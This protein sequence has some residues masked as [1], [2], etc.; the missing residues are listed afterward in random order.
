MNIRTVKLILQGLGAAILLMIAH[1]AALIS[2]YHAVLYHSILPMRSVVWGTLIDLAVASLMAAFLFSYLQKRPAGLRA[3]VWVFIAAR[4]AH[5]TVGIVGNTLGWNIPHLTPSTAAIVTLAVGLTLWSLRPPAYRAAVRGLLVLLILAG[6]NAVWMVPQLVYLGLQPQRSDPV[7]PTMHPVLASD[8]T[9]PKNGGRIVWLLFDELSYDQTFEHRVP[10]LAMP[11]FDEFR[12]QSVVF[13]DLKPVGINTDLVIP[14]LFLGKPVAKIRSGLDGMPTLQLAGNQQWQPFDAHA[15]L[16]SEAQ[17]QGW[18]TGVVG[19][20]NPYCRILAGTLDYCFWRMGDGE[21]DGPLSTKS[22]LQNAMSP[23]Q[24]MIGWVEGKPSFLRQVHQADL[25]AIMP[26]ATALI[27]DQ[28][29]RFVF[30]HLPVPHPP[31]IYDRRTGNLRGGGTYLDNLALSDR[32]M[33][34]LMTTINATPLAGKTTVIVCSDHSWRL[35]VWQAVGLFTK[36]E[37]VVSGGR[38]DPRPVLMIHLPGQ[39]AGHEVSE[40]FDEIRIHEIIERMLRGQ[41]PGLDKALLAGAGLPA[42]AKP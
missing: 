15:T 33:G 19:W 1:L 20:F 39:Q 38:F 9:A 28:K 12:S 35:S 11:S 4:I 25:A 32:V 40:P 16:F 37:E 6:C 22:S 10:G 5:T 3:L 23:I 42:A 27:R 30:I 34:E 24:N 21:L 8:Q 2:P 13:S 36:E 17:R 18:T 14:G 41:D 29:I 7:V 26:A 31:G